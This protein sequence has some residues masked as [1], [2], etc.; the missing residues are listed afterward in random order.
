MLN[1]TFIIFEISLLFLDSDI[2]K[3]FVLTRHGVNES[4]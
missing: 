3:L 2:F 4:D 1:H